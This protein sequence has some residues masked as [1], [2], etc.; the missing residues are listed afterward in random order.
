M[1]DL[2]TDWN[3]PWRWCTSCHHSTR[4]FMCVS[5]QIKEAECSSSRWSFSGWCCCWRWCSCPLLPEVSN[6]NAQSGDET[7]LQR[8]CSSPSHR[9][10]GFVW[11]VLASAP[12]PSPPPSPLSCPLVCGTASLMCFVNVSL[13]LGERVWLCV[14]L[15]LLFR[16]W[17]PC[18]QSTFYYFNSKRGGN[19][20]RHGAAP[21]VL[22]T[23]LRHVSFSGTKDDLVPGSRRPAPPRSRTMMS[24][25]GGETKLHSARRK[26]NTDS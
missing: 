13:F 14:T 21:S 3:D 15:W 17:R 6:A 16:Y 24:F 9:W 25:S 5:F 12:P 10:G 22:Q 11:D 19:G 4:N 7:L 2:K 18:A 20:V 23:V 26:V 1:K 8:F